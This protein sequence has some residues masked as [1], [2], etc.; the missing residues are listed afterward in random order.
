[1]R[2]EMQANGRRSVDEFVT[3]QDSLQLPDASVP[4]S[5]LCEHLHERIYA[6]LDSTPPTQLLRDVQEQVRISLGVVKEALERYR[7]GID[8]TQ[9]LGATMLMF[10]VW[11]N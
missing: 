1:M 9:T 7:C 8:Q 2:M 11:T 6:F 3:P 5:E 4:L 10:A